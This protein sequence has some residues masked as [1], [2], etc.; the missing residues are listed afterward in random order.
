MEAAGISKPEYTKRF[1]AITLGVL[2]VISP[3]LVDK[4]R[5]NATP[6]DEDDEDERVILASWV[7]LPM[8]LVSLIVAINFANLFHRSYFRFDPYWIHRVGGSSFGIG[9]FLFLLA[10]ILKI[11]SSF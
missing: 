7:I 10:I 11:K 2:A 6:D 9:L 5:Y 1:T 8:L 3:L 4:I